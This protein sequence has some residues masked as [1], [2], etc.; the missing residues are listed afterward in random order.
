MI[1]KYEY[2]KAALK[3]TVCGVDDCGTSVVI[4]ATVEYYKKV[5]KVTT[6][7]KKAFF[8]CK[9]LE[10][11][12]I[13]NSVTSIGEYAFSRCESLASI[14]IP[15]SVVRIHEC[16]FT[17]CESLNSIKVDSG[18]T[19]Y[20]SRDNCNAI[21]ETQTNTLIHGCNRT[22]IPCS[23][24]SIAKAAFHARKCLT[25]IVIHSGITNIGDYAFYHCSAL[26]SIEISD[27]V[28]S[29]GDNAFECCY[30]LNSIKI[31]SDNTIYDSR[32]DCNA[33]I[34]TQTNTLICGGNTTVISNSV[35]SIGYAAFRGCSGLK[36]IVIPNS[37]TSIGNDTFCH[38]SGLTSVEIPNSVTS[39][40]EFAFSRCSSL[41]CVEIP[42]SV[43]SIGSYA[44]SHCSS[45][46]R[47]KIYNKKDKITIKDTAIPD[48]VVEFVGSSWWRKI[49]H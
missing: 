5:Y 46:K 26:R 49:L 37:V 41:T 34:E 2:D 44:F 16:A 33:I 6:I 8:E 28:T 39:I 32:D 23:V 22:V 10:N 7:G 12:V 35:T 48:N 9:A 21:I 40:G 3:A 47:V 29:I 24:T 36:S 15:K 27:T 43:T 42:N 17:F 18:N 45:L 25:S 19:V 30:S 11:I 14:E 31:D 38:C 4:P 1:I 13:P 20:D